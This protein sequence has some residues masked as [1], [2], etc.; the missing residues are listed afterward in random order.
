MALSF[1]PRIAA[2]F[3]LASLLL[4]WAAAILPAT[5][6]PQQRA[7]GQNSAPRATVSAKSQSSNPPVAPTHD[8][9]FTIA[10]DQQR[11]VGRIFYADGNVDILFGHTRLRADHVEFNRDTQ[12]V[13]AHGHVMLDYNTQHIEADDGT[14][15]VRDGTGTFHHVR[16]TFAMQRRPSPTLLITP[17]PLYFEA[18]DAERTG[19]NSYRLHHAWFTVCE[20]DKPTWKFQA[21]E[22]TVE[23]QTSVRLERG[24]FRVFSVPIIL[25]PYASFP[26]GHRRQSGFLIPDVGQSSRKGT[27]L[28]ED[29]YWAPTDWMDSTVGAT[30]M[31]KRG[32]AQNAD[33]RSH[34][35][36]NARLDASYTGVIDRGLEQPTGPPLKQGGHEIKFD[37]DALL[38]DGWRA[39]A[40]LNQ[41]SSLTFR[42]AFAETFAQA[43]NSEVRNTAFLTRNWSGFSLDFAALSYKNFL[44]ATPETSVNLRTA[45]EA[46]FGSVDQAPF[47]NLPLYFS[48]ESFVDAVHRGD[49][50]TP[51]STSSFV[52][53][54]EFAPSVTMPLH[55][56]QW[57]NVT[58]SFTFRTTRY[59]AQL[60]DGAPVNQPFERTTEEFTLDIRP[61]TL[62]RIWDRGDVKWKHTIEPDIVYRY[63]NGVDDYARFIRF[64]EDE[65]LTDTNEVEYGITQRLYRRDSDGDAEEFA[66]WR[67]VQ[68]EYFDPTF[69]GALIPGERNV[70]Q[71]LDT[72]TPFAFADTARRFSPIISDFRVTPG[73]HYDTQFIVNYDPVRNRLTAIGTLVK[74]KPYKESF[75]TLA[76]F[77]TINLVSAQ[78]AQPTTDFQPRSNQIRMLGGYGDMTRPG[79]NATLGFSYDVEQKEYQDQIA[80]I[81]YNGSCCGIGL[82]YLRLSLGSI[83]SENQYRFVFLI[84]NLGSVGNLRRQEKIF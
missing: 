26:A 78:S 84:A 80:Q 77:S 60:E 2:R 4:V 40:E 22:A 65:T 18:L 14:Y 38:P 33:I 24:D 34:P 73:G 81:T 11:Q 51:F 71:A 68:K 7:N 76:H 8:E 75:L 29:F 19:P 42:L 32:W 48:F 52:Q 39:V 45:P 23:M 66:S 43:V 41:L 55:W 74:L 21:Q 56:G 53:R 44:S 16:A 82:E 46:R 64:D 79:W 28:G 59:G 10:A 35:W 12:K 61:P 17:N 50:V 15:N 20:P 31:S 6:F 54:M 57:L 9:D 62:D 27:F 5:A 37:F 67:L 25:F 3:R 1:F 83:R 13:I 69:G 72:L 49:T 36:E 58:P 63:V 47:H 30:Y 70:F